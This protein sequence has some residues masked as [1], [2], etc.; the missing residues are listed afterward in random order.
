VKAA[1]FPSLD[2]N[3]WIE[4]HIIWRLSIVYKT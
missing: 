4:S 3:M 1:Y 2:V